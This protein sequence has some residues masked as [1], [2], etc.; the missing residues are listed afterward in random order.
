VEARLWYQPIAYRWAQN[1]RQ[2]EAPEIDRFIRYYQSM[3]GNSALVLT[4]AATGVAPGGP[5]EGDA[6]E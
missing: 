5:G 3:S 2:R 1:L 4:R 6:E